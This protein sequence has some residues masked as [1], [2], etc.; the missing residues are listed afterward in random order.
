MQRALA[1]ARYR[2]RGGSPGFVRG[3]GDRELVFPD[4]FGN[5]MFNTLGNLHVNPRSGLPFIDFEPGGTLQLT[6]EAEVLWGEEGI[7]DCPAAVWCA[8]S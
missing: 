4:Y 6:G 3:A 1:H 8:S 7:A 5:S 2:H